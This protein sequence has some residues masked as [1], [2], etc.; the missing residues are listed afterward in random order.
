MSD[1]SQNDNP[2]PSPVTT[3]P[4]KTPRKYGIVSSGAALLSSNITFMIFSVLSGVILA[5]WLGRDGRGIVSLFYTTPLILWAWGNLGFGSAAQYM[6]SKKTY[7]PEQV[8]HVGLGM[9]ALTSIVSVLILFLVVPPG[10]PYWAG[11]PIWAMWL[12]PLMT[13]LMMTINLTRR[14]HIGLFHP[15]YAVAGHI[16]QG[17]TR[18]LG[19]LLLVVGLSWGVNGAITAMTL[20]VVVAAGIVVFLASNYM[21]LGISLHFRIIK[22]C[23]KYGLQNWTFVTMSTTNA[24][25]AIYFLNYYMDKDAVG[26]YVQGAMFVNALKMIP[27]AWQAVLLPAVSAGRADRMNIRT[28][29]ICRNGFFALIVMGGLTALIAPVLIPLLYGK[30]FY[31]SVHVIWITLPGLLF[32]H[33]YGTLAIDSAGRGKQ[34][35]PVISSLTGLLVNIGLC[36]VL[37]PQPKWY[38]GVIGAGL[39][40]SIA[41]LFMM[42]SM[43]ILFHRTWKVPYRKI[44][45]LTADDI[46]GYKTRFHNLLNQKKKDKKKPEPP[47]MTVQEEFLDESEKPL[48]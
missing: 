37:I 12:F 7:T 31:P 33:V 25:L 40:F 20:E 35:L 16:G 48:T 43:L 42:V 29:Q 6:V 11:I 24:S 47:S 28:L 13:F 9:G 18:L 14:M 5:R 41:C 45:I 38:G 21:R 36:Y 19:L 1:S 17:I 23:L 27:Q 15:H 44:L 3:K 22:D 32:L 10:N 4:V 26:L 30:E 39:A 34:I 2:S 8:Y 46:K